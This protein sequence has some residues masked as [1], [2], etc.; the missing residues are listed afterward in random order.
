MQQTTSAAS[1]PGARRDEGR[2]LTTLLWLGLIL[3]AAFFI[4][5]RLKSAYSAT[6]S[7]YRWDEFGPV[8]GWD[9]LMLT[10][11]WPMRIVG[12]LGGLLL[13]AVELRAGTVT[14]SLHRAL[15]SRRGAAILVGLV[16][17]ASGS[18]YLL[19]GQIALSSD[20]LGYTGYA[21][22]ARQSLQLGQ[23]P[24]WS[25]FAA[26]G[27]PLLQFYGFYPA[28][29]GLVGLAQPDMFEATKFLEL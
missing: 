4:H 24:I 13:I 15:A 6:Y 2:I 18:Y 7:Y 21:Y 28:L 27:T 20:A 25:N 19:P 29:A 14:N 22:L 11:R 1:R 12:G 16:A 9:A 23:W 10:L 5:W 26:M 17:L 8:P 3:L